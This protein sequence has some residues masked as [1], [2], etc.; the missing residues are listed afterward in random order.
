M[1]G[2]IKKFR[3]RRRQERQW[4]EVAEALTRFQDQIRLFNTT[5]SLSAEQVTEFMPKWNDWAV[6][7]KYTSTD[8]EASDE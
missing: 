8:K 6:M 1:I 5:T 2:R 3:E 7:E 4:R